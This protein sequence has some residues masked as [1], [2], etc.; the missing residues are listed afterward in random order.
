MEFTDPV[1]PHDDLT[2]QEEVDK[3]NKGKSSILAVSRIENEIDEVYTSIEAKFTK[4]WRSTSR[5]VLATQSGSSQPAQAGPELSPQMQKTDSPL[6]DESEA[7]RVNC[8]TSEDAFNAPPLDLASLSIQANRALDDL[9][10]RLEYVERSAGKLVN[11]ITTYF[12]GGPTPDS[13]AGSSS[14]TRDIPSISTIPG[15]AYGSTRYDMELFKLHTTPGMYLSAD[16]DQV[17][18]LSNFV[19]DDKTQEIE[20]L[21]KRYSETLEI[22]M[23]ALVPTKLPYDLFWYRYFKQVSKL[24]S[25]EKARKELLQP[26]EDEID[27]TGGR[28]FRLSATTSRGESQGSPAASSAS[29]EDTEGRTSANK[30]E[31]EEGQEVEEGEEEDDF[32]WDDGDDDEDGESDT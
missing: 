7:E 21:L 23:N 16:A 17:L 9:D 2:K 31:K 18:E 27:S 13:A 24:R 30:S 15:E 3:D 14:T 5:N 6:N 32:S 19:V 11:S 8:N 4:F 25:G 1:I 28:A 26:S 29:G 10:S 12:S 22:V 20:I